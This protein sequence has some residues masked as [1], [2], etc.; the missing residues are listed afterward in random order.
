VAAMRGSW[1]E[2][3]GVPVRVT[4]HPGFLLRSDSDL[5]TKRALWEDM[6]AVMDRLEM[7]VSAKQRAFFLPKEG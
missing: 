4:Y 5:G 2:F 7:P 1:H 6:L 3:E